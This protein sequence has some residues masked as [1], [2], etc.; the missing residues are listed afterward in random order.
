MSCSTTYRLDESGRLWVKARGSA[1]RPA[2]AEEERKF[3][4]DHPEFAVQ[5][6]SIKVHWTHR[7]LPF[8]A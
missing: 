6:L 2:S 7:P 8:A 1:A 5:A 3:Y 4:T